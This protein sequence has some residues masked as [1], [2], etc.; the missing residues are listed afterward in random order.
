MRVIGRN[1]T[2]AIRRWPTEDTDEA[3]DGGGKNE[4]KRRKRER[5]RE[6]QDLMGLDGGGGGG[7]GGTDSRL[8][9]SEIHSINQSIWTV[10]SLKMD[11]DLVVKWIPSFFS[12][13]SVF[14]R[15]GTRYT[16]RQGRTFSPKVRG[17]WG[18]EFGGWRRGATT[19]ALDQGKRRDLNGADGK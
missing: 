7:G 4:G 11:F 17:R 15:W 18:P 8:N 1:A 3:E 5:E 16:H 9:E 10:V 19:R 6:R 13:P 2:G 14:H 12:C